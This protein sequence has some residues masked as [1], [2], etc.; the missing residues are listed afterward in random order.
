VPLAEDQ[1]AVVRA[2]AVKEIAAFGLPKE[3]ST[4]IA[5]AI[6]GRLAVP[7]SPAPGGTP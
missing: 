5:N 7:E 3:R 6:V 1:L 4:Q 2:A